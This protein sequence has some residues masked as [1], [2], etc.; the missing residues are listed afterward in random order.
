MIGQTDGT[1]A[2][3]GSARW[4]LC[5]HTLFPVLVCAL[6]VEAHVHLSAKTVLKTILIMCSHRSAATLPK[7]WE[8]KP[9]K[10][11]MHGF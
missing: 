8:K 2:D 4:G 6:I 3:V 10:V 7:K 11:S 5:L 9:L 1:N